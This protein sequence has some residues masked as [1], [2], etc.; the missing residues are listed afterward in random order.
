MG[1]GMTTGIPRYSLS[2]LLLLLA[3]AIL[4]PACGTKPA[5]NFRGRWH[6]INRYAEQPEELPL[7]TA[8][9]YAPAPMDGTLKAMLTRWAR[10]SK[11]S[12]SYLAPSDY[13]LH[14]PVSHIRTAS[15]Q[16]AVGQLSQA[17]AAQGV[18]VTYAN[19]QIVVRASAS[20]A[21]Y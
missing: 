4:L 12:L 7:H 11:M 8:Y 2:G 20:P 6:P 1:N 21:A 16:E 19:G 17:Y 10:D 5:P 3:I 18:S 13:T 14:T 15:I 9:V